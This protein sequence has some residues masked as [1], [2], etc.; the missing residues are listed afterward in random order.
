MYV[1]VAPIHIDHAG[2]PQQPP[3]GRHPGQ[4]DLSHGPDHPPQR[5]SKAH[6]DWVTQGGVVGAQY[7]PTLRDVL[8]PP[9]P[10]RVGKTEKRPDDAVQG[11]V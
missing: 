11:V 6:Q 1:R 8:P 10:D 4:L 2:L 3:Q 7:S 5:T 9:G